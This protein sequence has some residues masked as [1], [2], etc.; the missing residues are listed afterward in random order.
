MN[1]RTNNNLAI[2]RIND[3]LYIYTIFLQFLRLYG[4]YSWINKL[5]VFACQTWMRDIASNRYIWCRNR[6][7]TKLSIFSLL[8]SVHIELPIFVCVEYLII[9]IRVAE[10][11]CMCTMSECVKCGTIDMREIESIFDTLDVQARLVWRIELT[12][13]TI[14]IRCLVCLSGYHFPTMIPNNEHSS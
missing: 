2:F 13:Y 11:S 8:R 6:R 12:M 3:V 7:S 10:P 9:E 5:S 4:Q 14:G 1:F